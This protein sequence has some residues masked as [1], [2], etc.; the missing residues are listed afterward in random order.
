VDI[1]WGN[2]INKV[3]DISNT[4][5]DYKVVANLPYQITSHILRSLLD[6]LHKPTS[7]T[8]MVQKE[9]AERIVAKPGDMSILSVAIQYYGDVRMVTNV[10]KGNFWPRPQVDSAIIHIDIKNKKKEKNEKD[11]D[12]M[13]FRVLRA[14]FSHKRKQLWRNLSTQLFL[15]KQI[16]M[17]LL[18]DICGDEKIR[19]EDLSVDQWISI[20][21]KLSKVL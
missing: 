20:V 11:F 13:F 15:E 10:S 17:V 4:L 12:I 2:A 21:K 7:I 1:M 8:I 19:A 3:E 18:H 9:V 16:V 6:L 14:G 5:Q